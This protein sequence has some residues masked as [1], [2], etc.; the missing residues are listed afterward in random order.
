MARNSVLK[1]FY[2]SSEWQKLRIALIAERGSVCQRCDKSISNSI[3]LIAHHK[4]ELTIENMT[5][6][7]I[8]LNPEKIEL[9]CHDCHDKEHHRF[10]YQND[11]GIYLVY[12]SPLSGKKT[13]VRQNMQRGDLVIDMDLLYEAVSMQPVYDKPNNLLSNVLGLRDQLIDNIKT[14]YGKWH[15]AWIIGGY[16]DKYRREQLANNLGAELIFCDVSKDECLARLETDE[17]L[18]CRKDEWTRY[19]DKWF[20]RYTV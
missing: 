6:A 2:A 10:G 19:I 11:H 7:N 14:R 12:G 4:T 8:S 5:D 18:R 15:C 20:E 13:F 9:I 17:A 1:S 3:D 16:E